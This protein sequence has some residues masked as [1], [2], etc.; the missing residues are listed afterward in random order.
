QGISARDAHG[1]ATLLNPVDELL[2]VAGIFADP[3]KGVGAREKER[4]LLLQKHDIE[5][6]HVAARLAVDHE[7]ARWSEAIEISLEGVL[8]DTIV[9]YVHAAIVGDAAGFFGDIGARGDDDFVG[10]GVAHEFRF[11][12]FRGHAD[13]APAANLDHLAEQQANTSGGGLDE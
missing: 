2:Q 4:A 13:D 12:V 3:G 5:G 10:A 6:R 11:F 8:A 7:I 9:D 1:N